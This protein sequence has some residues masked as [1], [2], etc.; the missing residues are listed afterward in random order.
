MVIDQDKSVFSR[1]NI[2]NVDGETLN[3]FGENV[4]TDAA[5]TEND[6]IKAAEQLKENSL[7][8]PIILHKK[9]EIAKEKPVLL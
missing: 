6:I 1:R 8:G 2:E 4:I 5:V 9:T 3:Q 7:S